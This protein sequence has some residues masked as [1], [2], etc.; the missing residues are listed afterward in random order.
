MRPRFSTKRHNDTHACTIDPVEVENRNGLMVDTELVQ[1]SGTP[2]R[3]A[4]RQRQGGS[5]VTNGDGGCRQ[6]L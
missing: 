6:R 1:Y 3:D 4:A 5:L 2:E